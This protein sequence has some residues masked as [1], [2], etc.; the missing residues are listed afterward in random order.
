MMDLRARINRRITAQ[1]PANLKRNH[2]TVP[3]ASISFDDFPRTA[4][5]NGGAILREHD[6]KATYYTAA[7]FVGR[8]VENIEQYNLDDLKAV[9]A[10]GHEIASHTLTHPRVYDLS[11]TQIRAQEEATQ[12]FFRQ[13]LPGQET[14]GFAYPYGEASVRTKRLYSTLYPLCRGI[15]LGVNA[16]WLD[17]GQLKAVGIERNSWTRERIESVIDEA[18]QK[19]AWVIFFTHDIT[20]TP[21]NYGATP[22]MLEH[23]IVTLKRAGIEILPVHEAYKRT[24][25]A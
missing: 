12:A 13:H 1:I 24:Q 20:D 2:S 10:A 18:V 16:T 7:G 19:N 22:E 6:I 21:S 25:M 3:L 17:C 23:A 9:A 14:V 15:R 11:N 5:T 4:W 8:I